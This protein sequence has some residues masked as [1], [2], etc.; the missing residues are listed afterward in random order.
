MKPSISLNIIVNGLNLFFIWQTYISEYN[1]VDKYGQNPSKYRF[2]ATIKKMYFKMYGLEF[3]K[4]YVEI[5]R[6]GVNKNTLH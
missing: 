1:M 2:Y 3:Y 4:T 5:W 6:D